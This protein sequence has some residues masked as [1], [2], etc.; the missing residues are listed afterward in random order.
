MVTPQR[1]AANRLCIRGSPG[2]P[3]SFILVGDSH[4]Y[5]LSDGL[6]AAARNRGV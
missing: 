3:P 4:A 6:F 1:V 2:T 5:A